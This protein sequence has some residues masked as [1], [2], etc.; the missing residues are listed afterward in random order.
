[1]VRDTWHIVSSSRGDTCH[2]Q[3]KSNTSLSVGIGDIWHHAIGGK[4]I[5]DG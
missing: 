4:S 5:V 3:N 2:V 1:M